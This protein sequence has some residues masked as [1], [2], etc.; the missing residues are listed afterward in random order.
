MQHGE[1]L[2][3]LNLVAGNVSSMRVYD[4]EALEHWACSVQNLLALRAV[5]SAVLA[6]GSGALVGEGRD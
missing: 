1:D 2:H 5:L 6:L 3:V 4:S